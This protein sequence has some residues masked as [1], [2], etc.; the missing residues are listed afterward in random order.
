VYP[1][2]LSVRPSVVVITGPS[3]A[4]KGTILAALAERMPEV[5]VAVSA[6][7]RPRR[8]GEEDGRE[9]HFLD[10]V[11]FTRRVAAG[12]FL[13]HVTYVSG[14]RYGTLREELGRIA[15]E[16]RVPA[17][18]L[19]TTGALLVRREVPGALTVFIDAPLEELERRLRERA[20][21]STGEIGERVELAKRQRDQAQEFDHVVVNDDLDRAVDG[22]AGLLRGALAA[23]GSI[24][25]S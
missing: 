6:T 17:L 14:N 18:E 1:F 21:E 19:E 20:T 22:V 9:Y 25:R 13:E 16:G 24:T 10:E 23:A 8:P 15:D 2:D 4:G 3:G 7:T 11:E 12:D 5:E